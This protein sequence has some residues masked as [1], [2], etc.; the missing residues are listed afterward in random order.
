MAVTFTSR[1][2]LRKNDDLS[3]INV[4]IDFNATMDLLDASASF[5]PRTD[6]P[7]SPYTGKA[8]ERTDQTTEFAHGSTYWVWNGSDWI[9]FLTR[10]SALEVE[11]ETDITRTGSTAYFAGTAPDIVSYTF[12]APASGSIFVT[13]AMYGSVTGTGL[14]GLSFEI[15]ES[16]ALGTVISAASDAREVNRRNAN[17]A[18]QAEFRCLVTGLTPFRTYYIQAMHRVTP[19]TETATLSWRKLLIERA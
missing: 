14:V 10:G 9:E 5:E 13:P 11:N 15:R 6:F 8:V 7:A 4:S 19:S 16:D 2:G 1:L 18:I 3:P 17:N 12:K